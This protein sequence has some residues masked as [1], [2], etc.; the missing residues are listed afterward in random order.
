MSKKGFAPIIIVSI[1]ALLIIIGIGGHLSIENKESQKEIV[2]TPS[3][4][5]QSNQNAETSAK[6]DECKKIEDKNKKD[7]CYW[8]IANAKQDL[9][10]C[11]KIKDQNIKDACYM[12][13]AKPK[14]DS[15]ICDK[16]ENQRIKNDCYKYT[17]PS[18]LPSFMIPNNW[19]TFRDE[20]LGFEIQ[21]PEG[22]KI[23]YPFG[24]TKNPDISPSSTITLMF[25]F[26]SDNPGLER[27]QLDIDVNN[28]Y[29]KPCGY[30]MNPNFSLTPIVINGTT[31]K[32]FDVSGDFVGTE[33]GAFAIEYCTMRGSEPFRLITQLGYWI[34]KGEPFNKEKESE[35]FTQV[36]STLKFLK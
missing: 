23:F 24:G 25:P 16:I 35:I 7:N 21:Y 9:S 3:P 8:A 22:T 32:R 18:I 1:I 5:F 36:L 15:S 26:V 12:A 13:I 29:K 20:N 10:I 33:T 28:E 14:Q 31:F 11:D 27:K 30:Y 6:I 2:I 34:Y 4:T 19:K 17:Q